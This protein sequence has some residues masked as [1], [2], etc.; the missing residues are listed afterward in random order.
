MDTTLNF[1]IKDCYK[2]VDEMSDEEL[3]ESIGS[4]GFWYDI[5]EGNCE[6]FLNMLEDEQT[7]KAC[8]DAIYILSKLERAVDK[9]I[10]W[11]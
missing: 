1:K 8:E 7:K 9:Y 10:N 4:M 3:D 11:C 5:D 6:H 2:P